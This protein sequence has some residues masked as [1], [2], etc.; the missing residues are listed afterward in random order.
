MNVSLTEWNK[1]ISHGNAVCAGLKAKGYNVKLKSYSLYNG[2]K[3]LA[4]QVFDEN[5]IFFTEYYSGVG[6][7]EN[8]KKALSLNAKRIIEEC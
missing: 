1:L 6:S 5:G 7:P 4:I 8:M 2:H 3:G